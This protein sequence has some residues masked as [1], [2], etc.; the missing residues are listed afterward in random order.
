MDEK[1]VR[2][3]MY[4]PHS[5]DKVSGV[6]WNQIEDETDKLVWEK[7][8][9]NFW[10]D[11]AIPVSNDLPTW[12]AM[13]EE[14]KWATIQVFSNLTMLDTMQ[15]TV[16][17]KNMIDDAI[18]A[19]EEAVL[20]NISFME[21]FAPGTLLMTK[22]G[23]KPIEKVTENDLV[24]QYDPETARVE[25]VNPTLVT[26]HETNE[27]YSISLSDGSAK[28]VVSGGHRVMV[29]NGEDVEAIEARDL[30]RDEIGNYDFVVSAENRMQLTHSPFACLYAAYFFGSDYRAGFNSR[31]QIVFEFEQF[32]DYNT[33]FVSGVL[34]GLGWTYNH[35]FSAGNNVIVANIPGIEAYQD[36]PEEFLYNGLSVEDSYTVVSTAIYRSSTSEGG[37]YVTAMVLNDDQLDHLYGLAAIAGVTL[38][39]EKTGEI[40]DRSIY[41]VSIKASPVVSGREFEI[42]KI[43]ETKT[44]YCVQV[45]STFLITKFKDST[46]VISGNCIHAKSYSTIFMTLASTEQINAGFNWIEN[47]E[48]VQK[49]ARM[50]L[51]F[52]NGEDPLKMKIASTLLE[53]FL[54]YSGFFWPLYLNSRAKLTNTNDIIR[55]II[56]D[57]C[58]SD[59]HE[60]LTP[61]GWKN[62]SE[63]TKDDLVAQY[64][65]ETRKIT[66]THPT[67]VSSHDAEYTWVFDDTPGDMVKLEVSP[68]HRMIFGSD[69]EE[70]GHLVIESDDI[71]GS[72]LAEDITL[73]HGAHKDGGDKYALTPVEQLLY[74]VVYCGCREQEDAKHPGMTP[75]YFWFDDDGCHYLLSLLD[76]CGY[77]YSINHDS[78]EVTAY[79]PNE[80]VKNVREFQDIVDLQEANS[81]WFEDF[82]TT[83]HAW[84]KSYPLSGK[85]GELAFY[86][87]EQAD[88]VHTALALSGR[89]AYQ[90]EVDEGDVFSVVPYDSAESTANVVRKRRGESKTVYG[91]Q[92]PDGFLLTRNG[93][94]ITVSGNSVHGYYIGYKYQKAIE[95][96]NKEEQEYYKNLTYELLLQLYENEVKYTEQ[97][98]DPLGLTEEVK[99]FLRYNANK[100][101]NNLGYEN[102]FPVDDSTPMASIMSALSPAGDETH[103]FFSGKSSN[104]II[105]AQEETSDDDW[106]F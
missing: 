95:K 48:Q 49:K 2:P 20:C 27:L 100:A 106:E 30:Y 46:P 38:S 94:S 64:S 43:N 85:D 40:D 5:N 41:S 8:V 53:S 44:V 73:I 23:F 68:K 33:S 74:G 67:N 60:L 22:S 14:E 3:S 62:I 89:S 87:K 13:T 10:I 83:A 69:A 105:G 37:N 12:R 35:D 9:Q 93:D 91:I 97:V 29:K 92:V 86:E 88:F 47:N 32:D 52:Y 18:T 82:I 6:N 1:V 104:Y 75:V 90:P 25:F 96:L 98:Y 51:D 34:D 36:N 103:D 28:Q 55:L 50:I 66:F 31:N 24:A 42:E 59:A 54:F 79:I 11:T 102:L 101:L 84:E 81:L 72:V 61:K 70:N 26:P 57:E 16:G 77:D 58:Y 71:N 21:A 99:K 7:L 63:I 65:E 19:Q 56:R 15:G 80:V 4:T 17:A 39:V 76:Q 45:P 78:C